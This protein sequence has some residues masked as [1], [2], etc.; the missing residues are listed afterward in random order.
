VI[1]THL[2]PWVRRVSGYSLEHLLPEHGTDVARA[3]VGTEGTCAIVV[4]ATVD[5]VSLPA[6]RV[7]LVL[8]FENDERA[9]DAIPTILPAG[10][11]TVE[12]I[13]RRLVELVRPSSRPADLP[14][15]GSWLLVEVGGDDVAEAAATATG[16]AADV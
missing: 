1:R 14:Q 7:L 2:R 6:A 4:R 11:L 3:L 10:P 13:D 15:G 5:L 8:G 16:I 12:G 9:A